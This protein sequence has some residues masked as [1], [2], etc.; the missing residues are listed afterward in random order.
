MDYYDIKKTIDAKEVP[1][2]LDREDIESFGFVHVKDDKYTKVVESNLST[3]VTHLY[4]RPGSR[5]FKSIVTIHRDGNNSHGVMS[6]FYDLTYSRMV[7]KNKKELRKILIQIQ[8]L[9]E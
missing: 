2:F 4:H 5:F 3:E 9:N 1:K 8:V 7:I 6:K